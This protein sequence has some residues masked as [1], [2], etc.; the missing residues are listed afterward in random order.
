MILQDKNL[1]FIGGVVRDEILGLSSLDIDLTYNGNAIEFAKTI[2]EAEILRINEPFGTVR[3]KIDNDE[4]DIA[5]TRSESYPQKGHLPV[6]NKIGCSLKEDV[7]RRDFTINALAKSTLTG[8]IIDYT[9][10]LE[11]IKNKTLRVLHDDSFVDDPT[12]I[13]RGL[14]FAVRF[15]FE[16]DEHTKKLQDDYLD[17]IN[18]DM[19]YKRLKKELVETFNLNKWEAFERFV[20]QGIYKLV[21]PKKFI[22]PKYNFSNLIKKFEVKNIW[23]IYAGLLPNILNLPLTKS[24]KQIVEG[25]MKLKSLKLCGEFEIYKIFKTVP[26]E[27]VIMYSTINHEIVEKYLNVIKDIDI[28]INGN[29]LKN[30]GIEPSQKYQECFD[31]ILC[32]KFENLK[33]T[34]DD[35]IKL[36][37]K[38]FQK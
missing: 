8:K 27:S 21:S 20:N 25:F 19:S 32:K 36:A 31:Y 22:L 17:N 18:Y 30:L 35:E 2:D 9:G 12:R 16:L 13:V 6:I 33:L 5:S 3:I 10:G 28:F 15:G 29:D 14:K 24:E 37:K 34:K 26:I 11:D 23:I 4:I 1:Y 7:M 38:F